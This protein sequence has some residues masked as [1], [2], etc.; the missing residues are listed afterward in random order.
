MEEQLKTAFM[1][2]PECFVAHIVTKKGYHD[3]LAMDVLDYLLKKEGGGSYL[4]LHRPAKDVKKHAQDR[5]MDHERV[6]FND[7]P[8]NFKAVQEAF[9]D[10]RKSGF[11]G[12]VMM[13]ALHT[14]SA[15][16][17]HKKTKQFMHKMVHDIKR[18]EGKVVFLSSPA[19]DPKL[20]GS[21]GHLCDAVVVL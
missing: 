2:L 21:V 17:D 1:Q 7:V 20:L 4:A 12:F 10:L 16:Q 19:L 15:G 14:L 11:Q 13:D 6:F 8:S 9:G 5:G 18:S 3:E